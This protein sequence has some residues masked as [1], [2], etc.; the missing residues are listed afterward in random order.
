[1]VQLT[2]SNLKLEDLRAYILL[3]E[4]P[5]AAYPWTQTDEIELTEREITQVQDI[6]ARLLNHD[7]ALMNEATIWARAIYPLLLLAEQ[8]DIEVWAEVGLSGQFAQFEVS[9]TADGA[10]GRC[11][12]GR[13]EAPFLVV[14]EAKRGIEAANPV[15]QLYGELLAAAYQNWRADRQEVQ[16][17][18]GC[19]TIGDTWKFLRA[20]VQGFASEQPQ[21]R[22]EPSREYGERFEAALILKILKKIVAQYTTDHHAMDHHTTDHHAT[23]HHATA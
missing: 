15:F 17:V 4:Q 5:I 20:E 22:V 18:F 21:M 3:Q 23:D 6:T 14:I 9:G 11:V 16:V 10:L 12:A 1:M 2:L 13:L 8:R 7:T 19:Y